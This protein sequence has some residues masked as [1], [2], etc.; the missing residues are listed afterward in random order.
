MATNGVAGALGVGNNLANNDPTA[1]AVNGGDFAGLLAGLGGDNGQ[2]GGDLTG[3]LDLGGLGQGNAADIGQGQ[4]N[5]AAFGFGGANGLDATALTD[6]TAVAPFAD[7]AGNATVANDA[8]APVLTGQTGN[9]SGDGK[10]WGDPHFKGANGH[11]Y[12]I[13]GDP[14]KAYNLLT[15]GT[16]YVHGTMQLF[17]NNATTIASIDAGDAAGHAF[18]VDKDGKLTIDG[19]SITKDGSYLGGEVTRKGETV[20]IKTGGNTVVVKDAGD[21]LDVDFKAVNVAN[22]TGM[23]GQSLVVGAQKEDLNANDFLVEAGTVGGGDAT[24]MNAAMGQVADGIG[25]AA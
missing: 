12:D 6:Q 17:G 24:V 5:A 3:G 20:T 19:K 21:H 8:A 10:V 9:A 16:I 14:G 11:G 2:A 15:D 23:W 18:R 7:G 1:N 4:G 13:M 22:P 25:N